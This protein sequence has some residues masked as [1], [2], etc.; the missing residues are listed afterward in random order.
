LQRPMNRHGSLLIAA[1][2]LIGA[3]PAAMAQAPAPPARQEQPVPVPEPAQAPAPAPAQAPAPE[4]APA[5]PAPQEQPAPAPAD[6]AIVGTVV[7]GATGAPLS[8]AIVILVERGQSVDSDELGG[9]VFAG[10]PPGS[11]TLTVSMPGYLAGSAPVEVSVGAATSVTVALGNDPAM[12]ETIVIVGSRTQR[13]VLESPVPV[14]VIDSEM[15]RMSGHSET[16][17]ALAALAP[18]YQAAHQTVS[19]GSDHVVPASMRGLGPD[20]VLVLLNGKRRHPTALIHSTDSF[21]R[22][23]T[24]VDLDAIPL[25]AIERI[26]VLRDG[27]AAQYGSDAIAGVI[28]IVLKD[29]VGVL[30]AV[31]TTGITAAGDGLSTRVGANYGVAVGDG[32]VLSFTGEFVQRGETNRAGDWQ[33]P[34]YPESIDENGNYDY[35]RDTE[36][37]E[38]NGLTREDVRMRVGQS[39]AM[40]GH[41]FVNGRLPLEGVELY[42]FGGASYR[43]GD[44][45]GFY[46]T[47]LDVERIDV[48]AHPNGFLPRIHPTIVDWSLG[49]GGRTE[50]EGWKLDLSANHGGN[51]FLWEVRDSVNAALGAEAGS[52]FDA[53][54]LGFLQNNVNLDAVRGLDVAWAEKLSLVAGAELRIENFR[55][56]AGEPDS[57][58]T[59]DPTKVP[60]SQVFPGYQA[61]TSEYRNSVG[62]YVGLESELTERVL[63]DVA[64]RFEH[65]SDFGST[66]T[67][68]VAARAELTD[69][70]AVR[71]A[72]SNGFRAPSLHQIWLEAVSTQF[73]VVGG[74]QQARQALLASN[75]SV[76]AQ[77]FGIPGLEEETSVNVSAGVTAQPIPGLSLTADA[78]RITIQDRV[79]FSSRL[80]SNRD[81]YTEVELQNAADQVAMLLAMLPEQYDGASQ[82]EFFI[83]AVDTAT[84]GLDLVAEYKLPVAE[85]VLGLTGAVNFSRSEVQDFHV[86]EGLGEALRI[87]DD[88][89]TARRLLFSDQER[90]R[91]EDLLP[92]QKGTVG[93][94]YGRGPWN[95]ATRARYYGSSYYVGYAEDNSENESYGAKVLFDLEVGYRLASG[96]AFAVGAENLFNTFPDESQ[97]EANRYFEQFIYR[98]DQFGMDGGFYY[99]R[100]AYQH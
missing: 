18:S 45:A 57:Y 36:L 40:V 63:L 62:T 70:I 83:N 56:M 91:I 29:R 50:I 19:D 96:L 4:Q 21:G 66:L 28:N 15:L 51:L 16:G 32:G 65:Y 1:V 2:V 85:G 86:P 99:L 20:Q 8:G 84:M 43:E 12:S 64:G 61:E 27:A 100:L 93:A 31:A 46:R 88:P 24:G 71:A 53:G 35:D 9:F 34:F 7:D 11:Y 14:D 73:E 81:D 68:K 95:A 44:A 79:M 6:R 30:D 55:Q 13:S 5:P 23:A 37:L 87:D 94:S 75:R 76:V 47:P 49:L 77:A 33:G 69:K 97:H 38:Q 89:E 74:T 3:A 10:V 59:G 52:T 78:Y 54:G 25:S 60:G 48:D 26:E 72:V 80:S 67:G 39:Q 42:T 92:R 90:N 58:A 82:V 17:Q 98:P 41:L 22:G